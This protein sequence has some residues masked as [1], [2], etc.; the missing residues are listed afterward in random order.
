LILLEKVKA[1]HILV[2][3]PVQSLGGRNKGMP[4]Y[5]QDHFYE[6]ISDKTWKINKFT[7]QTEMAFLVT[8]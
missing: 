8:K 1:E 4:D 2:S 7:F 3:F 5:Y 6:M